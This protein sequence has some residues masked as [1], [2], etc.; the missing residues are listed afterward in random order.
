[1]IGGVSLSIG[2]LGLFWDD[3]VDSRV[4]WA[5]LAAGVVCVVFSG[6]VAAGIGVG[7]AAVVALAA[8]WRRGAVERAGVVAVAVSVALCAVGILAL[9][10]GS[11][12]QFARYVGLAKKEHTTTHDVQTYSQRLLQLYIGVR[13]WRTHPIVG[14]GWSSIR[15]EQVYGP[16]LP[17]AHR[18]FPN[19]PPLAFPSPQ[20]PWGI[21]NAY[22]EVLAELGALGLLL[23]L[24][25]LG[26]AAWTGGRTS[27][28]GPPDA[29]I[30]GLLGLLWLVVALGIWLGQGLTVSSIADTAWLAIGL[31]ATAAAAATLT[32]SSS[33]VGY[34]HGP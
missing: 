18:R 6:A 12:A 25:P 24:L 2:F 28:R 13:V 21:D 22:V 29:A 5:A 11:I 33:A 1:M 27:L 34:R 16:Q 19:Q 14:A 30:R 7:A 4:A 17:A 3:L 10:A 23:F 31:I 9:R 32:N 20:H 8:A 26:T 15:E